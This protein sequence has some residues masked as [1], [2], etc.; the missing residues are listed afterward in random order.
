MVIAKSSNIAMSK[1]ALQL[2]ANTMVKMYGRLGIGQQ[3]GTGFPGEA[4]GKLP[5]LKAGQL[6][7][8]CNVAFGY[9]MNLTVLQVVQAYAIIATGGLKRPISLLKLDAP[10]KSESVIDKKFTDDVKTMLMRVVGAEGT[11]KRA[12]TISYTVAG[13]TGT[14]FKSI[15]GHY[16]HKQISS[17]VG[18]APVENP[19]IVAMVVIDEPQGAGTTANGGMVAA[20][21]FS[22]V[23]EDALRM[24]QV[25]PDA[26]IQQ[27]EEVKAF[28]AK[29]AKQAEEKLKAKQEAL[30]KMQ[31]SPMEVMPPQ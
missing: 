31:S 15:S 25:P 26:P 23:A 18:M 5:F 3:I 9:A 1:I 8:R 30:Q 4:S 12:R 29:T 21:A 13:K 27:I 7:E 2:D 17:F 11:G 10:G 16:T 14:A 6:L 28:T 19:R 24:L 22:K 20:P